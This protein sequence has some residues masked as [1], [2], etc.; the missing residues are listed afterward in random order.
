MKMCCEYLDLR[1]P[2]LM[3]QQ[4]PAS[5]KAQA[6]APEG[7]QRLGGR[8][9]QGVGSIEIGRSPTPEPGLGYTCSEIS[10]TLTC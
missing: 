7:S 9:G 6:S 5:H 2:F 1:L 3:S 8:G 4:A 10:G